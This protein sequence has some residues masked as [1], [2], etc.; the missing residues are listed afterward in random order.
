MIVRLNRFLSMCGAASRRGADELIR[1]GGVKVNGRVVREVGTK[2]NIDKDTVEVGGRVISVEGSRCVALNKPRLC[3]TTLGTGEGGKS[4]IVELI[5]GIPERVYPA[6]RLDYDAEGLLILTN[7]GELANR[8]HH[9]SYEVPKK[10]WVVL[11]GKVERAEVARMKSGAELEDGPAAPDTIKL[12]RYEGEESIL[13]IS[14]HE[15]RNRIVKRFFESF[16]FPAVRLRRTAIG[17]VVLGDLPPGQ[18]RD[19][20]PRELGRLR[21]YVGLE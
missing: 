7:D 8:I 18:W 1:E 17:P 5:T 6:G 11:R 2:V 3:L 19:L 21:R 14:F 4:T 15:G 20:T 10:Y 16:G 13:T 9:P 12:V